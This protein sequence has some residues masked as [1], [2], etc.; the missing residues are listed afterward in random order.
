MEQAHFI[1]MKL[2][3]GGCAYM[4]EAALQIATGLVPF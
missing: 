1:T 3:A 4:H 2:W